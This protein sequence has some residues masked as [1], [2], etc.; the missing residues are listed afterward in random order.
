[1][2]NE[3]KIELQN[4]KIDNFSGA[5]LKCKK[6]SLPLRLVAPQLNSQLPVSLQSKVDL[7]T[8]PKVEQSVAASSATIRS[9][10]LQRLTERNVVGKD[11]MSQRKV[12]SFGMDRLLA[13][14][15]GDDSDEDEDDD[16]GRM[17]LF[18]DL[19][20]LKPTLRA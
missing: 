10:I 8:T 1:M 16:K 11:Q 3:G 5:T 15:S 2:I 14:K 17:E 20:N 18:T 9:Q 19:Y 12:L 7:Q 6:M 13:S 4:V